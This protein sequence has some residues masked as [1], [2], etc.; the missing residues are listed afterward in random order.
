[1]GSAR[2]EKFVAVDEHAAEG[3]EVVLLRIRGEAGEFIRRRF[4]QQG[5]EEGED[6]RG[7][8]W[9]SWWGCLRLGPQA[10]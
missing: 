9:G 8:E 3:G 5:G 7:D 1:M 4:A 10:E 6:I 2:K